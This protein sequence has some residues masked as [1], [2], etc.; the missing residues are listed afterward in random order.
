MAMLN[1]QMVNVMALQ[2]GNRVDVFFF[3]VF[4]HARLINQLFVQLTDLLHPGCEIKQVIIDT[5]T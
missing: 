5:E 1:N 2:L 4:F 3:N